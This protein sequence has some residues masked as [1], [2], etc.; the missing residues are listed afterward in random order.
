MLHKAQEQPAREL[1]LPKLEN[2]GRDM[3]EA[4]AS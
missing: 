2:V 3:V 4:P 1:R